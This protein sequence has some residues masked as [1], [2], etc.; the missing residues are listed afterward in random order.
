MR[1]RKW[2]AVIAALVCIGALGLFFSTRIVRIPRIEPQPGG[3]SQF[4]DLAVTEVSIQQD[5]EGTERLIYTFS[6]HNKTDQSI[7]GLTILAKPEETTAGYLAAGDMP[8][9]LGKCDLLPREEAA[10][11]ENGAWGVNCNCQLALKRPEGMT[12]Q[13][14][15][16]HCGKMIVYLKWQNGEEAHILDAADWIQ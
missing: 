1:Q 8:A 11:T 10:K 4:F 16:A 12:D 14:I 9:P 7:S 13:E 2:I 5:S 6:V 3:E 15:L